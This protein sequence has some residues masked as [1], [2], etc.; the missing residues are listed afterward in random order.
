MSQATTHV[1]VIREGRGVAC[2]MSTCVLFAERRLR[3][4]ILSC[5]HSW[6]ALILLPINTGGLGLLSSLRLS[7]VI[8]QGNSRINFTA[9]L[10]TLMSHVL[11]V[12]VSV[13]QF[14]DARSLK[15]SLILLHLFR[16]CVLPFTVS[17]F[18]I[19]VIRVKGW[20]KRRQ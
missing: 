3:F 12:V 18:S 2:S 6:A 19:K 7:C 15:N 11:V 13:E 4:M 1:L 16:V 8:I 5:S 10:L 14:L 17:I 20:D 9:I